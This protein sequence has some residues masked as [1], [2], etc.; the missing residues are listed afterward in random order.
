[1][2]ESKQTDGSLGL[3]IIKV[4]VMIPGASSFQESTYV[5]IKYSQTTTAEDVI[6]HI[7][8]KQVPITFMPYSSDSLT[9]LQQLPLDVRFELTYLPNTN[10]APSCYHIESI[11]L[12]GPTII[13][14]IIFKASYQCTSIKRDLLSRSSAGCG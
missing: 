14:D 2:S 8:K 4:H 13:S 1:M 12:Q 9:L 6:N 5:S 10:A 7:R 11:V 3:P